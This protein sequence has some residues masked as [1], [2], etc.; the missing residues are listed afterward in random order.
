MK[1]DSYIIGSIQQG[2]VNFA[3]LPV[4]HLDEYT[5]KQEAEHLAKLHP[6]KKFMVCKIIGTCSQNL[7]TWE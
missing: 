7:I 1:K 6:N 4:Q 5:A 3:Q 2:I